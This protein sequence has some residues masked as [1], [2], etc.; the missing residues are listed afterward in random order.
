MI[1]QKGF[2]LIEFLLIVVIL[3]IIA[4]IAI[5]RL[6][7]ASIEAEATKGLREIARL[8]DVYQVKNGVFLACPAW[9]PLDSLWTPSEE[10]KKLGFTPGEKEK[11][12]QYRV[13]LTD[14]GYKAVARHNDNAFYITNKSDKI[15]QE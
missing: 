12:F 13:E 11:K 4:V 5:P 7:M 9:P 14:Y 6:M 3:G 10:F 15:E 1:N 2:T 8:E